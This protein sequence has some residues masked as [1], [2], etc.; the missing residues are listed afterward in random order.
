MSVGVF[1]EA[2]LVVYSVG[3]SG[4]NAIDGGSCCL[5]VSNCVTAR[6][7]FFRLLPQDKRR[8]DSRAACTAGS[9]RAII[10][11]M[12]EIT[13]SISTTVKAARAERRYD[14]ARLL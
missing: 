11:A 10:T 2:G 1:Q 14:M 5:E 3:D 13:T 6:L 9:S 12:I 4:A 8:P 7:R